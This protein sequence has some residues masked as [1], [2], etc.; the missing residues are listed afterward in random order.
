MGRLGLRGRIAVSY[1][2]ISACVA[3]ILLLVAGGVLAYLVTSLFRQEPELLA[4]TA[5]RYA[6][7]IASAQGAISADHGFPLGDVGGSTGVQFQVGPNGT[8]LQVPYIAGRPTHPLQDVVVVAV[9]ESGKV[10]GTSY[11]GLYAYGADLAARVPDAGPALHAALAGTSSGRGRSTTSE[12]QWLWAIDTVRINGVPAGA[13]YVQGPP[14]GSVLPIGAF[15]AL[16]G[17]LI[18]L[19]ALTMVTMPFGVA[20]GLL[21][22]RG[23]VRRLRTLVEAST[24]LAAGDFARR[25]V[26]TGGDELAVLERQFNLTAAQ[27]ETAI[28]SQRELAVGNA[29]LAER[30]RIARDLH[31]SISQELFSMRLSLASMA[32]KSS[33]PRLG[34]LRESATRA[35]RQMRALLLELRPIEIG[36]LDLAGALGELATDYSARLGIE[37]KQDLDSVE[38][39]SDRAESLLRIAQEAMSNIARHSTARQVDVSLHGR[40]NSIELMIADDGSGFDTTAA[41]GRRGLGLQLIRERV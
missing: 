27:L 19:F 23:P 11:P 6:S 41:T 13:V 21:T 29:R 24:E 12:D 35:I 18:L 38:L 3:L 33:D 34:E 16:T 36:T 30:A 40:D 5:S 15:P 7:S 2:I 37:I 28:E 26:P 14:F 4:A 1:V 9:D 22:M 17:V 31:E 10:A 20:F 32:A 25:V 8:S 39:H